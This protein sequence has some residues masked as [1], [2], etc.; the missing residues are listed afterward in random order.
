VV[1]V[2][3]AEANRL[4]PAATGTWAGVFLKWTTAAPTSDADIVAEFERVFGSLNPQPP[5]AT[6]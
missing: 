1:E 6:N 4:G 3:A 5:A 2:C